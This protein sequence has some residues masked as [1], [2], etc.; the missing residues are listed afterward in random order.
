MRKFLIKIVQFGLLFIAIVWLG[1]AII[2]LSTNWTLKL[3]YRFFGHRTHWGSSLERVAEFEKWSHTP[4][5]MPKGLI[6]GSS[7][8]Y[9]N[10]NPHILS[11]QTKINWFNYGSS[12]QSPQMSYYLLQQAFSKQKFDF[13]LL[14]I[15]GPIAKNDGLESAYDLIYNSNLIFTNKMQLLLHYPNVKLWLRCCYFYTKDLLNCPNYILKDSTNGTYLA[16]GFVCSMQPGMKHYMKGSTTQKI[17]ALPQIAQIAA[18]CKANSAELILNISPSLDGTFRLSSN[19]RKYQVIQINTFQNPM[20][21]YDSHHMTCVGANL[22]SEKLA[23]NLR[24]LLWQ[25]KHKK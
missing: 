4:S 14:D 12:N 18:L 10:I 20:N 16:K 5:Q 3:E 25:K 22:Y 7:T 24:S 11:A 13:I 2:A 8:A 23:K 15:Y 21:F 6:I 1:L 17:P 9:R 19:F